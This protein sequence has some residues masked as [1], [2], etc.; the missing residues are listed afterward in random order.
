[1]LNIQRVSRMDESGGDEISRSV[2]TFTGFIFDLPPMTPKGSGKIIYLFYTNSLI[3]TSWP[4]P[5][6][7]KIRNDVK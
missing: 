4:S 1:M 2:N 6:Y 5:H 3:G 7:T